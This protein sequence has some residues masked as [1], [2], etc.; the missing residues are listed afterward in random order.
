MKKSF[1]SRFLHSKFSILNSSFL[2]KNKYPLQ[3]G[4]RLN[5]L[6]PGYLSQLSGQD[7]TAQ[8]SRWLYP[9]VGVQFLQVDKF[10]CITTHPSTLNHG[11]LF[12]PRFELPC[13]SGTPA[14]LLKA[15]FQVVVYRFITDKHGYSAILITHCSYLCASVSI[16]RPSQLFRIV[17]KTNLVPISKAERQRCRY[18]I[19][20]LP[21]R[22]RTVAVISSVLIFLFANGHKVK[23]T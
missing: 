13:V 8:T 11:Y 1:T 23:L 7:K 4:A 19:E 22:Y 20:I 18:C 9:E 12:R 5:L 10:F 17:S 6:I 16:C 14:L 21:F 3:S 2:P 15:I